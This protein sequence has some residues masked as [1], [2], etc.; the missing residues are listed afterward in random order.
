MGPSALLREF[1]NFSL[2]VFSEASIEEVAED[3]EEKN[4]PNAYEVA[5][6]G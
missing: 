1:V 6:P 3:T 4:E 5:I 2:R